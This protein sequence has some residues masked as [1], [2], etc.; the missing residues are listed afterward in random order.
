MHTALQ[1]QHSITIDLICFTI[2]TTFGWTTLPATIEISHQQK[3]TNNNQEC[4]G[5][6]AW[7]GDVPA[8]LYAD[9]LV[10]K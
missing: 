7:R 3:N 8:L 2:L 6:A 5:A 4:T 10:Y 1:S 9:S